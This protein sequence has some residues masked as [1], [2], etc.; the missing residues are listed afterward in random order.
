VGKTLNAKQG[1]LLEYFSSNAKK[2]GKSWTLD[3]AE[4][5]FAH[6]KEL[7]WNIVDEILEIAGYP[8]AELAKGIWHKAQEKTCFIR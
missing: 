5:D 4:I 3:P 8:V 1:D 2:T 7:L 6:Y